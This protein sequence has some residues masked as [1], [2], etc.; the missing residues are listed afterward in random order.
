MLPVA[1]TCSQPLEPQRCFLTHGLFQS[2]THRATGH[3]AACGCGR[4][5]E[6]S[7]EAW[8]G[9]GVRPGLGPAPRAPVSQA[10]STGT[11]R[12]LQLWGDYANDLSGS[13]FENTQMLFYRKLSWG[14]CCSLSVQTLFCKLQ[15]PEFPAGLLFGSPEQCP[16]ATGPALLWKGHMLAA[17][18]GQPGQSMGV[19]SEVTHQGGYLRLLLGPRRGLA[20]SWLAALHS[21]DSRL[22]TGSCCRPPGLP[23]HEVLVP[24][25]TTAPAS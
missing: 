18:H 7:S 15:R 17:H 8:A 24:L 4:C 5:R 11:R 16:Y 23:L 1:A 22:L 19:T 6:G 20:D 9:G 21:P 13:C 25:E 2:L 14:N 12:E 3:G 10:A